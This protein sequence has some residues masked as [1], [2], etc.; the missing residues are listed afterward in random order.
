MVERAKA[1]NLDTWKNGKKV[2]DYFKR[3]NEPIQEPIYTDANKKRAA[4]NH[5]APLLIEI[6]SIV[7][8]ICSVANQY[9]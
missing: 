5:E 9:T 2:L 1:M 6:T 4:R 8:A 3:L 7:A